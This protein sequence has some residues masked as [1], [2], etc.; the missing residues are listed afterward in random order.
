MGNLNGRDGVRRKQRTNISFSLVEINLAY[1]RKA[2]EVIYRLDNV[3]VRFVVND[4]LR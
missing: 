4:L 1:F 2:D 3:I